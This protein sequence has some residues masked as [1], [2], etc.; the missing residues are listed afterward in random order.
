MLDDAFVFSANQAITVSA[1]SNYAGTGFGTAGAGVFDTGA[2]YTSPGGSG[3][4]G[5]VGVFGGAVKKFSLIVSV[6]VPFIGPAGGTIYIGLQDS[7][8]NTTDWAYTDVG[9]FL[10]ENLASLQIPG[11][12]LINQPMPSTGGSINPP[13][14][15]R[16]FLRMYYTIAGGPFTAGTL[17]ARVDMM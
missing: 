11:Q 6:G 4:Y 8:L 10:A 2:P 16:Q 17:N 9:D 13:N 3:G 7:A 15:L 1:A 12:I 14:I 5:S